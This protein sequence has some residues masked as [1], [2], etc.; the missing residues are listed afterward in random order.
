MSAAPPETE[1]EHRLRELAGRLLAHPGPYGIT[2]AELFLAELPP[3]TPADLI[4]P[5]ELDLVGSLARRRDGELT[6]IEVIL[7]GTIPVSVFL[8]RYEQ[9]LESHGWRRFEPFH[10]Q[11]PGGFDAGYQMGPTAVFVNEGAVSALWIAARQV[12]DGRTEIGL[13]YDHE[14]AANM[15]SNMP[16][17]GPEPPG[18]DI[19]PELRPPPSVRMQPQGSSGG[20]GR[21][22]SEARAQTAMPVP[23]LEAYFARQLAAAGWGRIAGSADDTTGWS[24]WA[25]PKPG[26]WRGLLLVLANLPGWRSL[27]VRVE[28]FPGGSGGGS[29]SSVV[30]TLG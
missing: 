14:N 25:V 24:S 28:T 16:G 6:G 27:S 22:T 12:E 29:W 13:R 15:M 11:R 1:R 21:W 10:H 26:N 4:V 7:D 19:L 23:E 18:W 8:G 5:K 20:G 30:S 9:D 2:T 3:D 17:P